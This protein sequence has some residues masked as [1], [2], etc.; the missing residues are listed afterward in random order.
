MLLSVDDLE[1]GADDPG[2]VGGRAEI[3]GTPCEP[4]DFFDVMSV[5]ER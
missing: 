1:G 3:G 4:D 2:H 5:R